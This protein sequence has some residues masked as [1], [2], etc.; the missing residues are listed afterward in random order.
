MCVF[1]LAAT[2]DLTLIWG[3]AFILSLKF[4]AKEQLGVVAAQALTPMLETSVPIS[5]HLP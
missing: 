1:Q 5:R 3:R 2:S 4:S